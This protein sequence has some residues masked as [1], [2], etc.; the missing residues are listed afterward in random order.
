MIIAI[1]YAAL[2]TLIAFGIACLTDWLVAKTAPFTHKQ[3]N[4]YR[5]AKV[6]P[7]FSKRRAAYAPKHNS[8]LRHDAEIREL[9]FVC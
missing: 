6:Q 9:P 1:T 2:F 7:Q 5:A 8:K 4:T 3:V